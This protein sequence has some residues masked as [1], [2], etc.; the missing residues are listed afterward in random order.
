MDIQYLSILL[1]VCNV[2]A[3][4]PR[5]TTEAAVDAYYKRHAGAGSFYPN[6]VPFVVAVGFALA[7]IAVWPP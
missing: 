6:I 7:A 3:D 2:Q 1:A 5:L 4:H